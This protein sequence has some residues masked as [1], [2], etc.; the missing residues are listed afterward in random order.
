[1]PSRPDLRDIATNVKEA[2]SDADRETL[3]EVLTFV[4]KEYVTLT[5]VV[6]SAGMS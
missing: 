4:L 1:M 6:L 2:F 5:G 3:L